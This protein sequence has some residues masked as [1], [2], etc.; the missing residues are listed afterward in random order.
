MTAK[1]K[2]GMFAELRERV[3]AGVTCICSIADATH[4]ERSRL[5]QLLYG[6]GEAAEAYEEFLAMYA[7]LAMDDEDEP[8]VQKLREAVEADMPRHSREE[9]VR[10]LEKLFEDAER[11]APQS[12]EKP[13][14]VQ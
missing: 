3:D 8:Q 9:V 10:A 7:L 5:G 1:P 6:E 14:R 12:D 2:R 4:I 11:S 13:G